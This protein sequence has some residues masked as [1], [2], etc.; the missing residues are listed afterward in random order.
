MKN[1]QRPGLRGLVS[2]TPTRIVLAINAASVATFA[3]Y[4]E[5]D[6]VACA[7]G[8]AAVA[9][10]VT[11]WVIITLRSRDYAH[12]LRRTHEARTRAHREKIDALRNGLAATGASKGVEQLDLIERKMDTL[13]TVLLERLDAGEITFH[14]YLS[15]AEQVYLSG[16]DNLNEIKIAG[17]ARRAID[18]AYLARSANDATTE[19]EQAAIAE[20]AGHAITLDEKIDTLTTQNEQIMSALDATTAAMAHTQMNAGEATVNAETA[21]AELARLA[22]RT[23]RYANQR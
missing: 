17:T 19:A 18:S 4:Y 8:L 20:R 10:S 23:A 21:M 16:L 15:T 14:R 5:W 7:A 9:F 6:P 22:E 1:A 12:H 13:R 11:A 3:W 2:Y